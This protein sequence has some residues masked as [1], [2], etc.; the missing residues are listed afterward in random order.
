MKNELEIKSEIILVRNTWI[1]KKI[2]RQYNRWI[3]R[4]LPPC[5]E[6]V[7]KLTASLDQKLPAK[8]KIIVKLHLAA[9]P[10][11][12]RFLEQIEFLRDV[13][14]DHDEELTETPTP[15][16]MSSDARERM[17]NALKSAVN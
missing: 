16:T 17:K 10:P 4:N 12:V 15:M 5:K 1:Y 11:C 2:K 6:I 14:H 8:E 3:W 9:C 13:I 7:K